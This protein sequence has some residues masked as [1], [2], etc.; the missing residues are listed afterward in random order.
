MSARKETTSPEEIE[1]GPRRLPGL[2]AR[3][4]EPRGLILFAHGS[5]SSR[6]SPRNLL[7]AEV[8]GRA[9]YATLLFD[10]LRETEA[11]DCDNAFDV[12]LLGGR[13]IEAV[14]FAR[15][16]DRTFALPFGLFGA[17]T[18]AAAALFAAAARKADID[19]VV[20]RGGRPDLAQTQLPDVRAPTLLLVGGRDDQVLALN[21]AAQARLGCR[22]KLTVVPGAGH[23]FEEPGALEAVLSAATDWFGAWL[24]PRAPLFEDRAAAGRMLAA[25]LARR[26][27]PDPV[28][29]ALPRGGAPV[30]A[31]I[32]RKLD[33][34]LD[35]ILSRK[36]GAPRHGELAL[37]AAVDGERPEIV[38]N[39]DIVEAL[40]VSRDEIDRL[41]RAQ[42]AEI[43]RRRVRYLGGSPPISAQG[44]TAILVDDGIATGASMEAAIRALKRR[45]PQKIIVAVPVAARAAAERLG[46]IVDEIV[47]LATPETFFG[48]G[49]FYRDFHQLDDAEVVA[50]M[51]SFGSRPAQSSPR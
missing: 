36:I 51:S 41:A 10:L 33:A 1:I 17:S 20:S 29:Y 9:G 11:G 30:A 45:G 34:P 21:R 22:S 37:G 43:E 2:L 50:L 18:G 35:L 44:R 40:G 14:D 49:E 12:A 7:A 3:P 26:A 27:P 25:A 23:L 42:F 47:A 46:G 13:V 4:H 38:L 48:I 24:R 32:A 6:F 19:A 8:F 31:E 5:G 28:V 16:D 15:N 39:P